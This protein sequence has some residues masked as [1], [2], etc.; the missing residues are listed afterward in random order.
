MG[1]FVF[2]LMTR[3]TP[4][5]HTTTPGI[6]QRI[7]AS[8]EYLSQAFDA[9]FVE[10]DDGKGALVKDLIML[11]LNSNPATRLGML[12]NGTNDI[13]S[14]SAFRGFTSSSIGQHSRAAPFIPK[15]LSDP[16]PVAVMSEIAF[17]DLPEPR[18][19]TGKFDF[20]GF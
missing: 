9:G 12:R 4:F 18:K 6:Y 15:L 8:G 5:D 14:H 13:W 10:S 19:Y 1:V 20:S 2:E 17:D 3:C 7:L 16:A 11:L